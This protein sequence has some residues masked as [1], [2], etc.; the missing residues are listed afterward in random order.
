VGA[1]IAKIYKNEGEGV[2]LIEKIYYIYFSINDPSPPHPHTEGELIEKIYNEGSNR[3]NI[4]Y[5]FSS[6][7]PPTPT[8]I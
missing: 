8:L 5:I 6:N 2:A 3:K 7:A 1:L 4:L